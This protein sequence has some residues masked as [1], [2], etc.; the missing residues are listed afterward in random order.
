MVAFAQDSKTGVAEPV[1]G[2]ARE[3]ANEQFAEDGGLLERSHDAACD[4]GAEAQED[5]SDKDGND[6][7]GV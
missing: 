2:V 3:H 7:V 4:D 6:R 5:Q 1:A